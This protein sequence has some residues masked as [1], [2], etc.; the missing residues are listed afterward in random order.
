MQ[1]DET[2]ECFIRLHFC[3]KIRVLTYLGLAVRLVTW[4]NGNM[5]IKKGGNDNETCAINDETGF[6]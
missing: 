2:S 3:H 4:Y 1:P 5:I 6:L